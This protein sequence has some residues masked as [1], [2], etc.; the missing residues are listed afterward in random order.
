MA[1]DH[2]ILYDR[3]CGLCR[4]SLALVLAWDRN[5]R[6]RPVALQDPE[7]DRLLAALSPEERM[8]SWHLVRPDGTVRSAG[9]AFESLFELLPAGGTPAAMARRFP[10][11]ARR[12]YRLIADNRSPLGKLI[13]SVVKM[14]ADSQVRQRLDN[15]PPTR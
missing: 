14:K 12:G 4:S 13:P 1:A 3:D 7:A 10:G 9:D 2:T 11:A 5:H 15:P 6:L 8:A